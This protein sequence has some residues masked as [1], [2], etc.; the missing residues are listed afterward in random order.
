MAKPTNAEISRRVNEICEMMRGGCTLG[1]IRQHLKKAY[2]VS[3]RSCDRYLSRARA[4]IYDATKRTDDDLRAESL[5]FY[6]GVRADLDQHI[7]W[8]LKA[9]ERLD[10]LMALDK[11]K[12]V[13]LT[14]A[15][16]GPATI[17]LQADQLE[18]ADPAVLAQLSAAFDQLQKIGVEQATG[19]AG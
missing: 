3:T 1:Q 9:Q 7:Q 18:K 16:G 8:R 6:E 19:G 11:P 5:A 12:K 4:R 17:R 15:N 10:S 14:D 2:K 13:A